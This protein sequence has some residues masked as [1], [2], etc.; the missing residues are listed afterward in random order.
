M[1]VVGMEDSLTDMTVIH[2]YIR[3]LQNQ[4]SFNFL[5]KKIKLTGNLV[6]YKATMEYYG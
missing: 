6:L 5:K 3:N 2:Y 4:T 1:C